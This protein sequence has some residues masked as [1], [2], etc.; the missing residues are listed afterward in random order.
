MACRSCRGWLRKAAIDLTRVKSVF[1]IQQSHTQAA[2]STAAASTQCHHMHR[3][4]TQHGCYIGVCIAG[5]QHVTGLWLSGLT[6][7]ELVSTPKSQDPGSNPWYDIFCLL[8]QKRLCIDCTFTILF[9]WTCISISHSRFASFAWHGHRIR[10]LVA[11]IDARARYGLP[12]LEIIQCAVK[13]WSSGDANLFGSITR[14]A[15]GATC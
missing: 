11:I 14:D 13:P 8:F 5:V 10:S 1:A 3:R 2:A 4:A 9:L 6:S 12:W 15:A 7:G